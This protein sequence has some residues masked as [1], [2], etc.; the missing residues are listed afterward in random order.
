M[1]VAGM[2]RLSRQACEG[3]LGVG[4]C[5]YVCNIRGLC[6]NPHHGQREQASTLFLSN[7]T[8]GCHTVGNSIASRRSQ[9]SKCSGVQLCGNAPRAGNL[10]PTPSG[11]QG[12]GQAGGW[13]N[14]PSYLE[15]YQADAPDRR[16]QPSEPADPSVHALPCHMGAPLATR[17]SSWPP[18]LSSLVPVQW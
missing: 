2:G 12:G 17:C 10:V 16:C 9:S 6:P 5:L 15:V 1:L 18:N 3:L 8:W 11:W 4:T 14:K 13:A 7:P